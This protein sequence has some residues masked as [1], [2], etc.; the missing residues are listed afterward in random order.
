MQFEASLLKMGSDLVGCGST[1]FFG[2]VERF[3]W[4]KHPRQDLTRRSMS[5]ASSLLKPLATFVV[6]SLDAIAPSE[7]CESA[8]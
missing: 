4:S 8:P 5:G 7:L 6:T 3:G 2:S 1:M